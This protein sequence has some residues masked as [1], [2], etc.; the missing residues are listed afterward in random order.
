MNIRQISQDWAEQMGYYR[1]LDNEQVS[2]GELTR[3][4]ASHCE[5]QVEGLHVLSVSDSNEINLQ[6]HV[7]RPGFRVFHPSHP[8]VEGR[9]W[10]AVGY[11]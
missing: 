11:R 7:E 2:I 6:A 9:E 10:L 4:L 1:F 5:Q 3:S 8:G